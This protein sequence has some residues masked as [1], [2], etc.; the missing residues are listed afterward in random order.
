[1]SRTV[2]YM[3]ISTTNESQTFSRQEA[4]LLEQRAVECQH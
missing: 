2:G 3:R 4:Q 1:M